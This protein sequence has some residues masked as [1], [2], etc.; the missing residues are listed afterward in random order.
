VDR[1][2][3]PLTSCCSKQPTQWGSSETDEARRGKQQITAV[4]RNIFEERSKK[5]FTNDAKEI[6]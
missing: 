1:E 5:T 2:L 3:N 6:K 4:Y